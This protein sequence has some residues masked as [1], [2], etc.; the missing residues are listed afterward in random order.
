MH[1]ISKLK[2]FSSRYAVVF[3]Q[4]IDIKLRMEM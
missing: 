1:Q 2:S 3:A 4:S